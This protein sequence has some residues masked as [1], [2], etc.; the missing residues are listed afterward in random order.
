MADNSDD[1]SGDRYPHLK[2]CQLYHLDVCLKLRK[3]KHQLNANNSN[4][5]PELIEGQE[6]QIFDSRVPRVP[7]NFL[8]MK[9]DFLLKNE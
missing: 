7:Y 8:K 4:G 6:W 3:T 2:T 5:I 1:Q 9:G